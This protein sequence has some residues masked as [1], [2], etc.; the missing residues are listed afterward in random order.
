MEDYILSLF[1]KLHNKVLSSMG[2]KMY[3]PHT[4]KALEVMKTENVRKKKLT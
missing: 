1:L 2:A 4:E 3:L